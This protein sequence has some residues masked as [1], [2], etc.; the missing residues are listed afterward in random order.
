[1]VVSQVKNCRKT[2]ESGSLLQIL[3]RITTLRANLN[4]AEQQHGGYTVKRSQSGSILAQV[5]SCGYMGS[6]SPYAV[7]I[8]L[9]LIIFA[10]LAGAGKSVL[11]Y[12]NLCVFSLR[13]LISR[14]PS[15]LQSFRMSAACAN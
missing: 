5:H 10:I 1:M 2:F 9:R 8:S 3:G 11:W 12:K 14:H 4:T 6:V 15:V 7:S 13:K